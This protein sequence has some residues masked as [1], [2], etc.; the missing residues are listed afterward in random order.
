MMLAHG[1]RGTLGD[2]EAIG[3]GGRGGKCFARPPPLAVA[4]AEGATHTALRDGTLTAPLVTVRPPRSIFLSTPPHRRKR[5]V[6]M[7]L[8]DDPV[9]EDDHKVALAVRGAPSTCPVEV[10]PGDRDG[11]EGAVVVA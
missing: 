6:V 4:I 11:D 3:E 7:A 9:A 5:G 2:G 1:R 10:A 8:E